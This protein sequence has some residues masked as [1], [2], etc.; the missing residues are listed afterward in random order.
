MK[1]IKHEVKTTIVQNIKQRVKKG[2]SNSGISNEVKTDNIET[3]VIGNTTF[4]RKMSN[5]KFVKY[6]TI[7]NLIKHAKIVI[8]I[9]IYITE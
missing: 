8:M 7:N 1:Y 2:V 5:G 9:A 4:F 3:I 6:I